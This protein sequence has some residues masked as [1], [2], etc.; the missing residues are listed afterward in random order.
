MRASAPLARAA[1]M[2]RGG[3]Q[4]PLASTARRET[5]RDNARSG[6]GFN[7]SRRD[8]SGRREFN[9]KIY[10]QDLDLRSRNSP[11]TSAACL[12]L[13]P[14]AGRGTRDVGAAQEHILPLLRQAASEPS[15]CSSARARF[16]SS[17]DA[18]FSAALSGSM[19]EREPDVCGVYS[20]PHRFEIV[21]QPLRSF[22]KQNPTASG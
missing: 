5:Y 14:H 12:V 22:K 6:F 10:H 9:H 21:G 7:S 2:D 20:W 11:K 1:G 16:N 17:A 13:H 18:A 3:Q 15:A 19:V 8:D 4:S